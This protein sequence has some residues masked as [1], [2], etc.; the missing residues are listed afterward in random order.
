MSVNLK[1]KNNAIGFHMLCQIRNT[2]RKSE[3]Q[4]LKSSCVCEPLGR[5][6]GSQLCK[7]A[8]LLAGPELVSVD[9][10]R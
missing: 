7:G 4:V 2:H 9:Q 10:P 6:Q 5:G 8:M 1:E 3:E